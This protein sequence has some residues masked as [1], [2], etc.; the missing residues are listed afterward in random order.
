MHLYLFLYSDCKSCQTGQDIIKNKKIKNAREPEAKEALWSAF[1]KSGE[2]ILKK[3]ERHY[4]SSPKT[5]Q[6][7]LKN[8]EFGFYIVFTC[9]FAGFKKLLHPFPIFPAKYKKWGLVSEFCT[10]VL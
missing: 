2:R 1:K 5:L 7:L 4:K 8:K 3:N 10:A 9:M 6:A